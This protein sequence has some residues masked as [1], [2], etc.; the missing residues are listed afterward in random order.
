METENVLWWRFLRKEVGSQLK[1]D[2]KTI[3]NDQYLL[4]PMER[5]HR[6][7]GEPSLDS[8]LC[9]KILGKMH[10][11]R[12][13]LVKLFSNLK[14]LIG[15]IG[16]QVYARSA[17]EESLLKR[18][19][20]TEFSDVSLHFGGKFNCLHRQTQKAFVDWK[21]R[22]DSGKSSWSRILCLIYRQVFMR[23]SRNLK[24]QTRR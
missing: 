13:F 10:W 22:L 2:R 17:K 21:Q 16:W 7:T 20:F 15:S 19:Q 1:R 23:I 6:G 5:Q 4:S 9:W 3:E 8:S 24:L 14:L 12:S 18:Q 11:I